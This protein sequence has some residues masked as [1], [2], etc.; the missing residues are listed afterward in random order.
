[1]HDY[2]VGKFVGR[3]IRG[4]AHIIPAN[5][6]RRG[7]IGARSLTLVD[8][9]AQQLSP[10]QRRKKQDRKRQNNQQ[11]TAFHHCESRTYTKCPPKCLPILPRVIRKLRGAIYVIPKVEMV[12]AILSF[13]YKKWAI[14]SKRALNSL[15]FP[16]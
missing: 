6:P 7:V 11:T 12:S 5:E 8:V 14:D 10:T 4:R 15:K 2:E 3:C 9:H 16:K 13:E 1:A